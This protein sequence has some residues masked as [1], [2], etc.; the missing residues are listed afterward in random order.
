MKETFHAMFTK[1]VLCVQKSQ[2][3]Q[4]ACIHAIGTTLIT[5]HPT[6]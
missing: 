4:Y 3:A 5:L 1:V 2:T 6:L